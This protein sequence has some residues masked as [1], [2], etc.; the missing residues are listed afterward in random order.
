M[1]HQR[2]VQAGLA[3][4]DTPNKECLPA[5]PRSAFLCDDVVTYHLFLPGVCFRLHPRC[6]QVCL[7]EAANSLGGGKVQVCTLERIQLHTTKAYVMR[8]LNIQTRPTYQERLRSAKQDGV[9]AHTPVRYLRCCSRKIAD[10]DA[11]QDHPERSGGR[12]ESSQEKN[13]RKTQGDQRSKS[14]DLKV[15][16]LCQH[17]GW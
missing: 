15:V 5:S 16:D 14:T 13:S 4:A 6:P 9:R 17:I 3:P 10:S 7:E 1:G 2:L 12:V 8:L 11:P